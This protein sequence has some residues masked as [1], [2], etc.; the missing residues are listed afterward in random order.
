MKTLYKNFFKRSS[1]VLI[2]IFSFFILSLFKPHLGIF[3]D[4]NSDKIKSIYTTEI[5]LYGDSQ[6]MAGINS[7]TLNLNYNIINFSQS[8]I[9]L[10]FSI[11]K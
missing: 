7:K 11:K 3:Y 2:I 8:E 9:P 10:F 1:Q 4:K 5:G 6:L